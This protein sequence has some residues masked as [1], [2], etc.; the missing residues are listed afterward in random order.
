MFF[1]FFFILPAIISSFLVYKV[2]LGSLGY[3]PVG[4]LFMIPILVL[5]G[6]VG[7]LI[8]AVMYF[9]MVGIPPSWK[10]FVDKP[11]VGVKKEEPVEKES[12]K[13]GSRVP[14]F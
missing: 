1:V 3:V 14:R 11:L 2:F 6:P 7:L 10:A 12:T 9:E 13:T 4:A 5:F 8:S